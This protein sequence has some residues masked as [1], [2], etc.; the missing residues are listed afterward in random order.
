ME[1]G[2]SCC[3]TCGQQAGFGLFSRYDDRPPDIDHISIEEK[4]S[5]VVHRLDPY[6]SRHL[7][8]AR[9]HRTGIWILFLRSRY[10]SRAIVG[11]EYAVQETM[12]Q[13][14]LPDFIRGRISTLDRGAELTMF[15]LSSYFGESGDLRNF[16]ANAD[17]DFR[18]ACRQ[19]RF[20][21]VYA[22]AEIVNEIQAVI[23]TALVPVSSSK[24]F[25][26]DTV[27]AAN[28]AHRVNDILCGNETVFDVRDGPGFYV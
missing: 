14:S 10:A 7:V 5:S 1:S 3:G 22:N 21:V 13:R 19:F 8:R 12:F 23:I 11:V 15:S 4:K 9:G 18:P 28:A 20:G 27:D 16:A 24:I 26:K 2:R 17:R 25:C 6:R